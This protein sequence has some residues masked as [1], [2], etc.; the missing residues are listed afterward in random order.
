MVKKAAIASARRVVAAA[1]GSKL[2]RTAQ[3]H[4]GPPTSVDVLVTD[5]DA[6]SDEITALR[7]HGITLKLV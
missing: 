2:G 7:D 5:A 4:V 6:P 1:D 3:A